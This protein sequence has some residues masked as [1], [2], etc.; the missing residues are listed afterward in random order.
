MHNPH[1]RNDWFRRPGTALILWGLPLG[2]GLAVY[3]I[4]LPLRTEA[5]VWL[6]AFVWMGTGCIL[7]ARRCGRLHCLI[8]GPLFLAG[9]V[10]AGLLAADGLV[11]GAHGL[12]NMVSVT[13]VLAL[14]SFV[15]EAVWH[16]YV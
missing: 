11:F 15:P 6:V 1:A 4:A 10:A 2:I 16:R 13:L 8:A 3:L 5:L 9:A 12:N 7:N 14:L